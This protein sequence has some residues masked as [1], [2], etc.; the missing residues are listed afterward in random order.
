MNK[1]FNISIQEIAA[2]LSINEQVV[3]NQLSAA[4]KIIR[5]ELKPYSYLLILLF[6]K[7]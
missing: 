6:M 5:N 4:L 1:E 7:L 3:R 2:K